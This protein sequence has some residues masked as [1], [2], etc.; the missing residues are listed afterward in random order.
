VIQPVL[1]AYVAF[2]ISTWIASLLFNL[3]LRFN[4]FGRHALSADQRL[5]S[6]CVGLL[7]LHA[8]L[9]LTVWLATGSGLAKLA[10]AYFGLLLLP[11]SAIF[12]CDR[13]WPRWSI[14][15]YTLILAALTPA[16]LLA[17]TG[18]AMSSP[19]GWNVRSPRDS[20]RSR[21]YASSA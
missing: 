5:G 11:V 1:I 18:R 14:T 12:N 10:M 16:F 20:G 3:L 7:V 19:A 4:R 9:A 8:L 15:A 6:T 17:E 21:R 13:G 2:A